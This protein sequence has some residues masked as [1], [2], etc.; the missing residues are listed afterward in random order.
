MLQKAGQKIAAGSKK[1]SI[2][3]RADKF[4]ENEG[5]KHQFVGQ[6]HPNWTKKKSKIYKN[7]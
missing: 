4:D 7:F 1:R 5:K 6:N 2:E 3:G